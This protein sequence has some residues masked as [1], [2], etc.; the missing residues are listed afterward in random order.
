MGDLF[1]SLTLLRLKGLHEFLQVDMVV[2]VLV[3]P[4]KDA[5]GQVLV[6]YVVTC[7]IYEMH[8]LL[9]EDR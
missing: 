3:Q 2:T 8:L 9:Q 4:L 7:M 1:K 5:V 6:V